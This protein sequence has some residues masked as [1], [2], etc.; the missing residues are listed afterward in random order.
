MDTQILVIEDDEAVR[1]TLKDV[2]ELQGYQVTTA[3]NGGEGLQKL[4]EM[5]SKPCLVL[6]DLMMPNVNG[7]Q[8]LDGQRNDPQLNNIPVIICSAYTES[9][10]AVNPAAVIEKPV[11]LQHLLWT[12]K[13]LSA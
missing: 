2:L 11:Q 6:L 8:F 12:V 1:Q 7:W 13:T 4:K 9:A 5:A 10:K 3:M